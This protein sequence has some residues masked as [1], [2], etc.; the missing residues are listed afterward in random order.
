MHMKLGLRHIPAMVLDKVLEPVEGKALSVVENLIR[1]DMQTKEI[2][3]AIEDIYLT[4]VEKVLQPMQE[5]VQKNRTS[6]RSCKRCKKVELIKQM[7]GGEKIYRYAQEKMIPKSKAIDILNICKKSDAITVD[8]K[9]ATEI[10][11]YLAAQDDKLRNN[12][13]DAAKQILRNLCT[14]EKAG[15]S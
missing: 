7:K 1:V 11:D 12:T 14:M 4:L 8:E 10:I 9:K 6:S 13:I 2:W 3:N 15:W 5:F